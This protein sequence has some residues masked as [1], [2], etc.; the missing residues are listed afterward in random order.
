VPGGRVHQDDAFLPGAQVDLGHLAQV[1]ADLVGDRP[2]PGLL[3]TEDLGN[4]GPAVTAPLLEEADLLRE[5]VEH[6]CPG[7]VR[8]FR[9]VVHR[10]RGEAL[11]H[12]Q[13]NRRREQ[14]FPHL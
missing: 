12:E 14:A 1:A 4:P 7:N 9:D 6:G 5:V 2:V 11:L 10:R 13:R 3:P 8:S